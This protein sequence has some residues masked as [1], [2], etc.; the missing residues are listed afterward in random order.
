MKRFASTRSEKR[1]S[2]PGAGPRAVERRLHRRRR[3]PVRVDDPR[4]DRE[5]DRDRADDRDDP[6]DGDPHAARK[7][8]G[9]AIE[10]V[11]ELVR[12][13]P[14]ASCRRRRHRPRER[15]SGR[16]RRLV[17]AAASATR[18]RDRPSVELRRPRSV[19]DAGAPRCRS[20]DAPDVLASP[21]LD[22]PVVAREEDLRDRPAAELGRPR[23]VRVLEPAVERG[24]EALDLARALA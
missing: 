8:P 16:R 21:R 1:A 22:P 23:V 11:V 24:G 7:P 9:D 18:R 19:G 3:D 20:R 10:R 12:A 2:Q 15:R 17:R 5:H 4:L 14:V 13:A 6:V